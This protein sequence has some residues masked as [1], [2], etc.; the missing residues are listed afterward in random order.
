MDY[1]TRMEECHS[2]IGIKVMSLD[3][4]NRAIHAMKLYGIEEGGPTVANSITDLQNAANQNYIPVELHIDLADPVENLRSIS[5]N[6]K[7]SR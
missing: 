2:N 3:E 1:V 6:L 7:R 4:I 5:V